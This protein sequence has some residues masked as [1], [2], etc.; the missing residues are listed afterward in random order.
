MSAFLQ[1]TL[2]P[3]VAVPA[4]TRRR[5][6]VNPYAVTLAEQHGSAALVVRSAD[7]WHSLFAD[8]V[9]VARFY[10][11]QQTALEPGQVVVR[12]PQRP[13]YAFL[14]QPFT[15][16]AKAPYQLVIELATYSW[17]LYEHGF[18]I[19]FGMAVGG[20]TAARTSLAGEYVVGTEQLLPASSSLY[21]TPTEAL[22]AWSVSG[23]HDTGGGIGFTAEAVAWLCTAVLPL[24]GLLVI[25][26]P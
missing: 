7:T 1:T 16:A 2:A 10:N 26:R 3:P 12:P 20:D 19:E 15:R 23:R 14:P 18:A 22:H 17:T 8:Q 6:H 21:L 11:R 25:V 9:R 24:Y 13:W 5:R 4:L